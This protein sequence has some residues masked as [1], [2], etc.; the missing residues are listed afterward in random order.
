MMNTFANNYY[1]GIV[2][3]GINADDIE[4]LVKNKPKIPVVVVNREIPGFSSVSI[5]NEE[6]GRI[7]ALHAI[8]NGKMIL[9]LYSTQLPLH[10]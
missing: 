2:L 10:V 5:D 9:L 4:Y 8:Q 3:T 1:D 7:A 6:T